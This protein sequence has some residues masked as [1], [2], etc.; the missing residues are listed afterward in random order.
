MIKK[1]KNNDTVDHTWAG[2]IFAPGF[3]YEISPYDRLIWAN[4]ETVF[5][6]IRNGNAIVGSDSTWYTDPLEGELYLRQMFSEDSFIINGSN[7]DIYSPSI[8]TEEVTGKKAVSMFMNILTMMKELYNDPTNPI[9]TSNFQKFIG[10]GGR[11]VEHLGRTANLENIHKKHGWHRDECRAWGFQKP[12]NLLIYYSYLNSFN[13][14]T[15]S[16]NNEK[17]AQ[18]MAKYNLIVLGDGIENP[19]HPDYANT[20]IIIPRI[21]VLNPSTLI[22]GYVSTNQSYANFQTKV[23]QWDTLQIHGI[24]CD[25]SGYDYG[26]V[27][28]N[29]RVAFNQKIDYVHG[30]TYSNI[31]FVNSWNIDHIIGIDNDVSYPNTT[32][33][34]DLIVS[35]LI[36]NDWYLLESFPINTTSYTEGF[37]SKTDWATRGTKSLL[38]RSTYGINLA[39][40]SIIN[41]DN[42]SG[43]SFFDFQYISSCMFALEA[44]GSSD[45]YYGASSA[46]VTFWTRL[47]ISKMGKVWSLNPSVQNDVLDNDI[48]LRYVDFGILKLDF[49]TSTQTCSVNKY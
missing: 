36:E 19:S 20:Q 25:E 42:V 7:L 41:N 21:K 28:T 43:Q 11:E 12:A 22:F 47:D 10:E 2:Q 40:A 31:A 39:S 45:N 32:W 26:T 18:D 44:V 16:W 4:D 1:I 14:G 8:V 27:G 49:S 24:F 23:D 30:K 33:N 6:N 37:E 38:K 3:E 9:Y 15:N 34:P 17:V 48:Y 29:G 13:S 5:E 46:T 35:K